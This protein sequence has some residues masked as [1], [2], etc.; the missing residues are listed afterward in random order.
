M[1]GSPSPRLPQANHL[2]FEII[3]E[4]TVY[5]FEDPAILHGEGTVFCHYGQQTTVSNSPSD[6]YYSCLVASFECCTESDASQ[7]LR[8][9]QW[10][11]RQSMHR[12][13]DEMLY[14][15]HQTSLNPLLIGNLIWSRL[16][17]ELQQFQL[18]Q[19]LQ[20]VH[21]QLRIATDF[22]N[23]QY[24]HALSL[25]EI[26]H[27]AG[28]S[29]SHLHMLFREYLNESPHQYLIQKRMRAA[30]HALATSDLPIKA[31]AANVGYPNTE[32]F[33][34]AFRKFFGR[35]ASEYRQAYSHVSLG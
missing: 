12:F 1:G 14:A 18:Q 34:R 8:C 16:L 11:D 5:G 26:A 27:T 10:K 21:P 4:G 9:F 2:L 30:G 29:V 31:I 32:N 35:S 19:R 25:E 24:R 20:S 3:Q 23:A 17:F 13:I 28:I 6:S 33:C 15:F 22:M 7:W